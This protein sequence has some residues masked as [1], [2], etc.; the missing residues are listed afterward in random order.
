MN[1][2]IAEDELDTL[3]LYKIAL[4]ER[5]HVVTITANGE[6]CLKEFKNSLEKFESGTKSSFDVV[7]LDINMP[8]KD[9][10]ETAKEIIDLDPSQRI[11]F[12]SAY[13]RD[14][15]VNFIKGF[16]G[17]VTGVLQKPI[18]LSALVSAVE[19]K[20]MFEKL[21]NFYKSIQKNNEFD[22]TDPEIKTQLDALNENRNPE[23]WYSVSDLV[24]G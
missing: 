24:I 18:R 11:I 15:F 5:D 16:G 10:L 7:I 8:K 1:I 4:D 19:D 3:Y 9:G 6:A 12:C 21:E 17:K 13:A 14:E 2:L 23:L 20:E 22:T